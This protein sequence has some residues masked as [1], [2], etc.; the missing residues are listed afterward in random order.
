MNKHHLILPTSILIGC[1]I[2]GGAYY[3]VQ[4]N[5]QVSIERQQQVDLQQKQEELKAKTDADQAKAEQD[6][7]DYIAKR[8]VECLA[9]YKTESDKFNNV[10]RWSYIE[11]VS[12]G[13]KNLILNS[14]TCE[15][16]YT[17]TDGKD[18]SRFF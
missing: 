10:R 15:I 18:F 2:L 4:L 8:K 3:A 13:L 7:R 17:G 9:I 11:P 16:I 5:K 12:S 6:K 1:V 14:D